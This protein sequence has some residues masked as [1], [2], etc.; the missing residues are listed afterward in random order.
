FDRLRK[1]IRLNA[2]LINLI[3]VISAAD[4]PPTRQVYDVFEHLSGQVDAQLDKLNS[5]LEES[6]ADFNAAVKAAQV[7]AVVV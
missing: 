3:S 2:K 1:P 7:P 6:V 4:A 5:I